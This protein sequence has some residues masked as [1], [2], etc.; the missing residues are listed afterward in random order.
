MGIREVAEEKNFSMLP[1]DC[2]CEILVKKVA[3]FCL[4][5]KSLPETKVK[6]FGLIPL[7]EEIFKQTSIDSIM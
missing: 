1:R 6:R 3:T 4:Y 2:S 5:L 7:A